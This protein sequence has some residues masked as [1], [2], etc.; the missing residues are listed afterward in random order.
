MGWEYATFGGAKRVIFREINWHTCLLKIN[1]VHNRIRSRV[2]QHGLYLD[3]TTQY[4][5]SGTAGD[6][7]RG[8]GS[9]VPEAKN[10]VDLSPEE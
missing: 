10:E 5:I 2:S 1:A 9:S 4:T 6:C 3:M 7:G 8:V